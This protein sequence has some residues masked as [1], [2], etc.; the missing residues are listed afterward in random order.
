MF[1]STVLNVLFAR[2][3]SDK[4]HH[5][6]LIVNSVNPGFC[7]SEFRR[8]FS[9]FQGVV[10]WLM[11]KTLARSTEEGSRQ[12]VWAAVGGADRLDDLRGAYVSLATVEESSDYVIS[13]EGHWAQRKLWVIIAFISRSYISSAYGFSSTGSSRGRVNQ[14]RAEGARNRAESSI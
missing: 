7:I 4:L 14:D 5:K 9:G 11:E 1:T 6:S 8:T 3:L 13:Q 12:L 10:N 2:A